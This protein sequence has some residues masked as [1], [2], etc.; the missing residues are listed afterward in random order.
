MKLT[1]ALYREPSRTTGT[2]LT[3]PYIADPRSY[4]MTRVSEPVEVDFP[5]IAQ[6]TAVVVAALDKERECAIAAHE[7]RLADIEARRKA[8]QI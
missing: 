8:V 3:L 1:I 7:K 5:D 2:P 4:G 6:D